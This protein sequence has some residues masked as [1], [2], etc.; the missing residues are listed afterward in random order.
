MG[1][2]PA[3]GPPGWY[4]NDPAFRADFRRRVHLALLTIAKHGDTT[5]LNRLLATVPIQSTRDEL[6]KNIATACPLCWEAG[7]GTFRK[8][9][10]RSADP[11][12]DWANVNLANLYRSLWIGDLAGI[13][14]YRKNISPDDLLNQVMDALTLHR[15]SI[16]QRQLDT[17]IA[18][19]QK[20][21][22][23][24]ETRGKIS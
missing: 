11:S 15:R 2:K 23:R 3:E 20:L 19:L 21:R 8:S 9:K 16:N 22:Q 10:K 14:V 13:E 17:L 6:A 18:F 5:E 24:T 7:A 4:P 1:E 12:F